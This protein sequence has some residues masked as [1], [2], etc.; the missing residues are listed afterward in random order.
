MHF[1]AVFAAVVY[2]KKMNVARS[3]LIT[4]DVFFSAPFLKSSSLSVVDIL[5]GAFG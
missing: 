4:L 2:F 3:V 1:G 5:E